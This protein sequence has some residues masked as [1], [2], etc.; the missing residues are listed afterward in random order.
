MLM[1]TQDNFNVSRQ[2]FIQRASFKA[3]N[4]YIMTKEKKTQFWGM[5]FNNSKYYI[6]ISKVISEVVLIKQ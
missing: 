5:P 6:Q 4:A 3:M 2:F 1:D